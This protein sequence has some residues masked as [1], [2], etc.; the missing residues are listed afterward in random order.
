[1]TTRRPLSHRRTCRARA[2]SIGSPA[3]TNHQI[4]LTPPLERKG[5]EC[6]ASSGNG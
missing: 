2:W 1:M 6:E 4:L 3:A 5:K